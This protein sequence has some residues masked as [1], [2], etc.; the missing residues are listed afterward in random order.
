M[1]EDAQET[2][3]VVMPR[4]RMGPYIAHNFDFVKKALERKVAVRVITERSVENK[5]MELQELRKFR[6]FE[7]GYAPMEPRVVFAL[8]DNREVLLITMAETGYAESP[9]V[10]SNNPGLIELARGYFELTW[11]LLPTSKMPQVT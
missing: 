5:F 7:I 3:S 8:V 9:A 4:R 10:W 1:I 11:N 6:L 2:L